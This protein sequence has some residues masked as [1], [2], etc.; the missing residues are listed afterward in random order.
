MS[1]KEYTVKV[2]GIGDIY[3]FK[4]GTPTHH[5]EGGPAIEYANGDKVYFQDGIYH[6]EDGPAIENAN[7]F[8]DFYIKG[9]RYTE[10]QFYK[11]NKPSCDG[12]VVEIDGVKYTLTE[13]KASK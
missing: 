8:K 9:V 1:Y 10:E 4:S 5:R 11:R 13:M 3:W 2:Y 6:R 12:K 7:G